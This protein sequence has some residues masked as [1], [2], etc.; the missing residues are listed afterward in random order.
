MQHKKEAPNK[1]ALR[2]SAGEE[3]KEDM[4]SNGSAAGYSS[5]Q[6][7]KEPTSTVFDDF[8]SI[9]NN[10]VRTKMIYKALAEDSPDGSYAIDASSSQDDIDTWGDNFLSERRKEARVKLHMSDIDIKIH[11]KKW[12]D[13][14]ERVMR[15]IQGDNSMV[16]NLSMDTL[17]KWGKTF[18]KMKKDPFS[19]EVMRK[20]FEADATNP[21]ITEWWKVYRRYG[22]RKW[23]NNFDFES[24]KRVSFKFYFNE[25]IE[26]TSGI[27]G[28]LPTLENWEAIKENG[29]VV[30]LSGEIFG[31]HGV[32]AGARETID[33]TSGIPRR[34]LVISYEKQE[35]DSDDQLLAMPDYG[36]KRLGDPI[37]LGT[38]KVTKDDEM[39]VHSLIQNTI[40]IFLCLSLHRMSASYFHCFNNLLSQDV[41]P[42]V[43]CPSQTKGILVGKIARR[44]S[45]SYR[46]FEAPIRRW[47]L[48]A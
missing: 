27:D 2:D 32:E 24:D 14:I 4:G 9:I 19:F 23:I 12:G 25:D 38:R 46:S 13:S 29:K 6:E 11:M 26:N 3:T 37:R 15:K 42:H 7:N 41:K 20:V 21:V 5:A 18:K 22:H 40:P 16:K 30:Q 34:G 33:F 39:L 17:V 47:Y 10:E 1:N 44:C 28:N 35:E 48:Q 31:M 8:K 36:E 43:P 45:R